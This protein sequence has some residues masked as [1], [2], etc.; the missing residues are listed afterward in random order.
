MIAII[1]DV[2]YIAT[3]L[4]CCFYFFD[5][6]WKKH[7]WD[8]LLKAFQDEKNDKASRIDAWEEYKKLKGPNY[9]EYKKAVLDKI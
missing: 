5:L 3:I 9:K 1:T 2:F 7:K 6:L 4:F 8:I